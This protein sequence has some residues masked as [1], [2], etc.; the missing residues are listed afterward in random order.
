[1][2][3]NPGFHAH[4]GWYFRRE[5]DGSVRILAPD[6]QATHQVVLLDAGTWASIVASVSV[7]EAFH[8]GAELAVAAVDWSVFGYCTPCGA[9]AG[10]PCTY[11]TG[12]GSDAEQPG[13]VREV[14]HFYRERKL[15]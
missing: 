8:A 7:A 1:M 3:D 4:D 15:S 2:T 5:E 11:I 12:D 14:A 13:A 9:T 6:S 10:Q